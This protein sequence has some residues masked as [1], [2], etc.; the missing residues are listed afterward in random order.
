MDQT[1]E[2]KKQ[3]YSSAGSG[4]VE[5]VRVAQCCLEALQEHSV[6]L[7]LENVWLDRI[8]GCG[9]TV[10]KIRILKKI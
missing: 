5:A 7:V 8:D 10:E 3:H 2:R 4:Q 1:K 9:I 6:A